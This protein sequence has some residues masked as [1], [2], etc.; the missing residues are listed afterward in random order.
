MG[1]TTRLFEDLAQRQALHL[2]CTQVSVGRFALLVAL[3]SPIRIADNRKPLALAKPCLREQ[4]FLP[5]L[6]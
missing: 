3:I 5:F 2:M 6:G 4:R 1:V